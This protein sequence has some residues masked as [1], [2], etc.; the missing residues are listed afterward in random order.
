MGRYQ[1]FPLLSATE[2]LLE[3]HRT[4][5]L[6]LFLFLLLLLPEFKSNPSGS[7]TVCEGHS[8]EPGRKPTPQAS[9][10]SK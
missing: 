9:Q 7:V 5:F 4:D 6:L 10:R 2:E 3:A 8:P 1:R